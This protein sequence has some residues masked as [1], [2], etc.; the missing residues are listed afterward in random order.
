MTGSAIN[1]PARE[2][3]NL[4]AAT[5]TSTAA[6]SSANTAAPRESL[7]TAA[8]ADASQAISELTVPESNEIEPA[9]GAPVS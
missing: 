4:D 5:A 8:P 2:P 1:P 3:G 7:P 6:A 9:E